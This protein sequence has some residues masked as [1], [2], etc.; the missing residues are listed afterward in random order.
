MRKK[1]R[2]KE[3]QTRRVA[4]AN[5]HPRVP[6]RSLLYDHLSILC[7]VAEPGLVCVL[8]AKVLRLAALGIFGPR[9][10]FWILRAPGQ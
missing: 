5:S 2:K 1:K 4:L 3:F 8:H 7:V 10:S 6:T 9:V